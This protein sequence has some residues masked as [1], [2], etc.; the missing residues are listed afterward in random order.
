MIRRDKVMRSSEIMLI[1]TSSSFIGEFGDN[2]YY[3]RW[4]DHTHI[5]D[6]QISHPN[7]I[8]ES[9]QYDGKTEDIVRRNVNTIL[10]IVSKVKLKAESQ[11]L[12]NSAWSIKLSHICVFYSML[13]NQMRPAQL[14]AKA[15]WGSVIMEVCPKTWFTYS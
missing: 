4:I 1:Q 10:C 14:S 2:I 3:V 13:S 12:M 7:V 5:S 15:G 6:H 8:N 11:I 9:M